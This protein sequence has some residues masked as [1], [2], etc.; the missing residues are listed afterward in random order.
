MQIIHTV[1][2]AIKFTPE[3]NR[4]CIRTK[5]MDEGYQPQVLNDNDLLGACK[6]KGEDMEPTLF[7]VRGKISISVQD[8]GAGLSPEQLD[9]LFQ[10]GVQFNANTLQG[11]GTSNKRE[12]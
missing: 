7:Q 11:G 6:H 10:P 5:W 4:I 8:T 1:G 2:N 9:Q 12:L 3:G